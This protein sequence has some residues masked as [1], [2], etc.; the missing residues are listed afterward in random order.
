M[1]SMTLSTCLL[2]SLSDARILSLVRKALFRGNVARTEACHRKSKRLEEESRRAEVWGEQSTPADREK[3]REE[4]RQLHQ[5]IRI[6]PDQVRASEHESEQVLT[7]GA[8][9]VT[10]A[11]YDQSAIAIQAVYRGGKARAKARA[12]RLEREKRQA[13]ARAR[14]KEKVRTYVRPA[15]DAKAVFSSKLGHSPR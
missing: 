14:V 9:A 1:L 13:E 8:S 10:E 4:L 2:V 5:G 12:Y 11:R 15:I 6:N 7:P 3:P